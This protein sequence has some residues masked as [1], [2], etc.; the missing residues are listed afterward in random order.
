M[1]ILLE[2]LDISGSNSPPHS[3][4][5]QIT[6]PQKGY[7]KFPTPQ[8]QTTLITNACELPGAGDIEVLY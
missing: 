7:V 8:A 6:H 1:C 5:A 3:G 2:R 4:K